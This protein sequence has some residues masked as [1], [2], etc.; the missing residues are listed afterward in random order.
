MKK[1]TLLSLLVISAFTVNAQEPVKVT[2][3]KKEVKSPEYNKWTV[4]ATLGQAKG[5]KPYSEGYFSSSSNDFLGKLQTNSF[6]LTT[7]YMISPKFGVRAGF[8]FDELKN[9]KG[10]GSLPFKM[11]IIGFSMQGVVNASRLFDIESLGKFGLLIHGGIRVDAMTSKTEN[12]LTTNQNYNKSEYNG[13]LILGVTPQYR[14]SKKMSLMFDVS[15]QNNLRQHFNW[16]GSN[17]EPNTNLSAQM[18][19]TSLGLSYS[20]GGNDIHGD[21]AVVKENTLALEEIEAL[22][23]RV[24]SIETLMNDTDKD[25]VADYLDQENNSTA[26]VTVDS[27]GK[28]VDLNK[29]GVPDEMERYF[30][31]SS[32][33]ASK[34]DA[35]NRFIN[36]GYVSVYFDSGKTKPTSISI[37]GI[38]FIKTYMKNNPSKS[39]VIYG[40]ADE[41]VQTANN[42]KLATERALAV[43]DILVRSGIRAARLFIASDSDDS[44]GEKK[45]ADTRKLVKRVTF[46]ILD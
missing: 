31:S 17:A 5:L 42:D 41:T 26:G 7:R 30:N 2:D 22:E 43:K 14:L 3:E 35:V 15:F 25:G 19:T 24:G 27:R 46:K 38:E 45:S 37:E 40:H 23:K 11:Q 13:G 4:E 39:I 21:W 33:D 28:M 20:I 10:N 34:T 29:N 12:T 18:I 16:D 8:H 36:D 44:S 6:S 1:I 32:K 9:S